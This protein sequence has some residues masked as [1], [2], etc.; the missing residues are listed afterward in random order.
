MNYR[1][2]K[3]YPTVDLPD[4]QWP[5]R[6]LTRAPEWVSVDLRDGNQALEIPMS[7]EEK[8]DFFNYLVKIGFK[9]IEIGFP[10]ASDTEFVLCSYMIENDL[11]PQDVAIQVLTQSR[12]HIIEKT[13]EAVKGA[14]K[15]V[16][17]LYNSTSVVQREVVFRMSQEECV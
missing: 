17:H 16:I 4:R 2:Y 11:I 14:P 5:N 9:T 1:K 15:A 13:F 12:Q 10:A 7:L 8:I 6:T 3:P